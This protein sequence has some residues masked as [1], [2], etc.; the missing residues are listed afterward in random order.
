MMMLFDRK[1]GDAELDKLRAMVAKQRRDATRAQEQCTAAKE[2][3]DKRSQDLQAALQSNEELR[4]VLDQVDAR[5]AERAE[6][7]RRDAA[8]AAQELEDTQQ[9]LV[10]RRAQAVEL[11]EREAQLARSLA[12]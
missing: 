4:R 2:E 9:A 10:D 8:R 7:L 12:E 1:E 5:A 6:V 11:T 3:R